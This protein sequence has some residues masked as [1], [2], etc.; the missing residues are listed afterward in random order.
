MAPP[1]SN[2]FRKNRLDPRDGLVPWD[3]KK[4]S[5][6]ELVRIVRRQKKVLK[7]A[8]Y[9][10]RGSKHANHLHTNHQHVVLLALRQQWNTARRD[11]CDLMGVQT[12]ILDELDMARMPHWA[13]LH[14]S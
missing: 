14:K 13:A 11:F 7:R 9:P 2:W 12:P 10:L 5:Q 6:H 4:A 1:G 3:E 8:R